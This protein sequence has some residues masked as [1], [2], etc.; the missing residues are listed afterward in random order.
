MLISLCSTECRVVQEERLSIL[1]G[2]SIGHRKTYHMNMCI[3]LNVMA[4]G[5]VGI[6][7]HKALSVVIKK[8]KLLTV[9]LMRILI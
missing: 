2:D 8:Q 3:I 6:Y 9:N 1:G 4:D 5:A 7:K